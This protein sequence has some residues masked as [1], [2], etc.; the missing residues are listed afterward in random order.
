[1]RRL[2]I[3]FIL[4]LIHFS[5]ET[6]AQQSEFYTQSVFNLYDNIGAYA[7]SYKEMNFAARYRYQWVGMEGAPRHQHLSFHMPV[8]QNVGVG[9]R[10]SNDRIG[11]RSR[12]VVKGTAAYKLPL[13][14]GYLGVAFNG[15]IISQQYRLDELNAKNDM[16]NI[17]INGNNQGTTVAVDFSM[18]WYAREHYLGFEVRN[19]NQPMFF[20]DAFVDMQQ[21]R[22]FH[23]TGAYAFETGSGMIIRPGCSYRFIADI[24][25]SLEANLGVYLGQQFWVGAGFRTDFGLLAYAEWEINEKFRFGYSYDHGIDPSATLA[26]SSHEV[27]LGLRLSKTEQSGKSIRY[28]K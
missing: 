8:F 11:A 17:L 12:Q 20:P 3:V 5:V 23:I 24:Q 19:I 25:G 4:V 14:N 10:L 9:I 16:S 27:F 1:M 6:Q 18:L 2:H 15:G 13:S 7:G 21:Y 28:F 22:M 26:T